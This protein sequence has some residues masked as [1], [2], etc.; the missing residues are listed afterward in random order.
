MKTLLLVALLA[1]A[2]GLAASLFIFFKLVFAKKS[3]LL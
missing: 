3:Q 1:A 2:I